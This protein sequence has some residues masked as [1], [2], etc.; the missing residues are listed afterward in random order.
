MRR[1]VLLTLA[2]LG[3]M[4]P[5]A[6]AETYTGR[7]LVSLAP[8]AGGHRAPLA[9][10][11]AARAFL[12]RSG[13]RI[14]GPSV[15]EIGLVTVRPPVGESFESFSRALRGHGGV[16]AVVRERRFSLRVAPNDPA[17]TTPETSAGTP[18]GVPVEWWPARED[19]PRA[20]D[21]T[22]GDGAVVAVIDTGVDGAHPEFQGKIRGT[23]DFD[24]NPGDGRAT[25]DEIGHGTH[26]ASL[27]CA[28]SNNAVGLASAGL[29]CG[30]LIEKSDLT[31]ASVAQAIVDA[32]NRGVDAINMSFGT[33]GAQPASRPVVDAIDYAY[34]HNVLMAAA[35]A[36]S[37]VT[38]QGD[39]ANVLQPAGSGA[40][41]DQGKGLTVTSADYAGQRS[42]FAGMGTEVSIAAYGSFADHGGPPGLLGAFPSNT[43]TLETGSL[44]SPPQPPC[45]NCRTMFAGD[46]RYAYL[47]GTSMSTPMVTAVG[48]LIRHLNPDLSVADII[49][50]LKITAQRP[51]G[52]GWAPD[53]GWGILDGGAALD[54]ARHVDRRKPISRIAAPL[55]TRSPIL[56]LKW[57]GT[58]PAPAGVIAPGID[59]YE[60]WRSITGGRFERIAQTSHTGLAVRVRP[61]HLYAFYTLAVDR[62]GTREAGPAVIVHTRVRNARRSRSRS[63]SRRR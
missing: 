41:I 32:T 47:Q 14:D 1:L 15:P 28:A 60:V 58:D 57:S 22:R 21:I 34:S 37:P 3:L 45:T 33:D 4:A 59:H 18:P 62:A 38:E 52:T 10:L 12:A 54:L 49:R 30:L 46:R 36:D 5:G 51:A 9:H 55:H 53:L 23:A 13:A 27:A 43:T 42:S 50:I 56:H 6:Q 11:A 40:Q 35:A 20:W 48:A 61:G 16:R 7:V 25:T 29:D 19:L 8:P 39:P 26:V 31:D 63:R 2:L 17:L 44:G 24:S